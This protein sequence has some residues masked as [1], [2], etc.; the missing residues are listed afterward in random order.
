MTRRK[1]N[2]SEVVGRYI[3][4]PYE[5]GGDGSS[6]IDC[7]MLVNSVGR[8]FGVDIPDEF[9]G[10]TEENYVD[11][12]TNF[13]KQA[14]HT[15]MSYVLSLGEK[16]DLPKLF[17]PDLVLF[18]DGDGELGVG[19]YVGQGKILAGF[20]DDKVDLVLRGNYTIEVAIRWVRAGRR[21]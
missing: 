20:V 17:P 5:L 21:D 12:W 14:K 15:L 8:G 16:I 7:L 3:G 18:R 10:V 6:G 13:P 1:L 19:I 9:E 4:M 11:L 2:L